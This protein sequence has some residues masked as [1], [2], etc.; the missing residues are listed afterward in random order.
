[1]RVSQLRLMLRPSPRY[2]RSTHSSRLQ[3]R[4]EYRACLRAT[5]CLA[6]DKPLVL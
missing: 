3:V 5:A 2:E 1:M 4:F 6:A